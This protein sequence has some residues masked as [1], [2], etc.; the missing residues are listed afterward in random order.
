[1]CCCQVVFGRV[2]SG[3]RVL[4]RIA[5]DV[6]VDPSSGNSP[7]PGFSVTIED[8]GPMPPLYRPP[9]MSQEPARNP[10]ATPSTRTPVVSSTAGL[11][12]QVPVAGASGGS[13]GSP[14]TPASTTASSSGPPRT[15]WGASASQVSAG[16]WECPACRV[17]NAPGDPVCPFCS[18]KAPLGVPGGSAKA[19]PASVDSATFV[20]GP[21][22]GAGAGVVS[23]PVAAPRDRAA[24][25]YVYMTIRVDT[26]LGPGRSER[27]VFELFG[28][29]VPRTADNFRLLCTGEKVGLL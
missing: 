11:Q 19:S 12:V 29:K 27:V 28:D 9:P 15:Q 14:S 24:R 20:S 13:S 3:L 2:V 7:L 5:K 26:P 17:A 23:A 22:T 16:G 10:A 18:T 8:C 6:N 25:S 4:D 21:L 1:M